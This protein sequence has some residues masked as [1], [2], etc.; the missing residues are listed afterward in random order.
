M[1]KNGSNMSM[2][3]EFREVISR[4]SN[5]KQQEQELIARKKSPRR[6][7]GYNDNS[8]GGGTSPS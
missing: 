8:L 5:S 4:D 6:K 7:K 1:F 2:L 3:T